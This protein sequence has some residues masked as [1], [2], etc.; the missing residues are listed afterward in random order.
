MQEKTK[1]NFQTLKKTIE[2]DKTLKTVVYVG[3]GVLALFVLGKAFN[4][5]ATTVRGFNNLKSAI[6]G[7]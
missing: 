6:N 7:I 2:S 3:I 1:V 5:L 4:G